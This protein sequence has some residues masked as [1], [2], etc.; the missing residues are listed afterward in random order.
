M[1]ATPAPPE[2]IV[3][4][5]EGYDLWSLCYDE[6]DNPLILLEERELAPLLGDRQRLRG[7]QV[8]DVGCG[9]GRHTLPLAHAGAHVTALDFSAGMLARARDKA[10]A[11]PVRFI[12]HDLT[13]PLPL[14]DAT[15][16]LVLNCLVLEHLPDPPRFFAE[17]ARICRPQGAIVISVMHPAM[18]LRGVSAR[19]TNP[20]TG[21]KTYPQSHR[22]QIADYVMAAAR[23]GLRFD[24][25]SEHAV[26]EELLE[27]SVS[28]ARYQGWP[29]LL[30]MRLRPPG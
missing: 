7:L 14:P 18:L 28:A 9:T 25:M 5:Q 26:D 17:L 30:L 1:Q 3:P 13:R 23:A 15:F 27:R 10:A 4:T 2:H 29:M 8:A 20:H 6:E 24:H 11:L 12:E 19:F 22:Q 16:D 21:Q